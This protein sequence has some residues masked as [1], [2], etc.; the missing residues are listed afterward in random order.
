MTCRI[1]REKTLNILASE[2]QG[3]HTILQNKVQSVPK[4][5]K[6]IKKEVCVC[7]RMSVLPYLF[8]KRLFIWAWLSDIV[9]NTN[10][11]F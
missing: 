1:Y 5:F 8:K 9:I 4:E 2:D 11:G 10:V 3:V 6:G 7:I